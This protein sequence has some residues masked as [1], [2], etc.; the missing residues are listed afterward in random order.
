MNYSNVIGFILS[1]IFLLQFVSGL[2]LSCYFSSF[3]GFS[4]VYY[5]M[6]EVNVGW[7]VRFVHVM[8]ASIFMFFILL[9]WI[10]GTWIRLKLIEQIEYSV[11][12][13]FGTKIDSFPFTLFGSNIGLSSLLS[14][15]YLV[16]FF[17]LFLI[18][19]YLF[20]IFIFFRDWLL[21]AFFPWI[22]R[23]SVLLCYS[24]FLL[25]LASCSMLRCS[26]TSWIKYSVF[27]RVSFNLGFLWISGLFIWF[28]S[29]AVSF[30]GYCLCWGQMSY[31]GITVMI[32]IFTIL[33]LFGSY[34]GS[35]L[36]CSSLVVLNKVFMLHF[37]IGFIIGF[38]ILIHILILHLFSSFNLVSNNFSMNL[39]FYSLFFKDCFVSYVV[40][41]SM[42][43]LL[44]FEPDIFGSCD[45]LILANPMSTPNHIVPE[46]YF[47]I[48]YAL[49]RS[50]PNK[51]VGVI[52]ILVFI[53]YILI[54]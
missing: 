52:I 26:E 36:W 9:H 49:L 51:T 2:L 47:L 27:N 48:F 13:L 40:F 38:L 42:S 25:L 29:L 46:W 8:G 53:F 4:A 34:I 22:A 33:P 21:L 16:S 37:F 45:N 6:I 41:Y 15:S 12:Y 44:F 32:N 19:D 43:L 14:C 28:F 31:W 20:I 1:L 24:F 5:I 39:S 10:R 11:L 18:I 17:T 30:L 50:F 3:A 54:I 7:L 23:Y 35:Y